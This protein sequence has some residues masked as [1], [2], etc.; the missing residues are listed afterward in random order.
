MAKA[1]SAKV[2][3]F[4]VLIVVSM[5]GWLT[6]HETDRTPYVDM[7]AVSSASASS[8]ASD[9][10]PP[11][12]M[13][14]EPLE[15]GGAGGAGGGEVDLDE[16]DPDAADRDP[17]EAPTLGDAPKAVKFG[18]ILVQYRGAQGASREARSKNEALALAQ[19][20]ARQGAEDF[21]AAVKRGDE[22]STANAGRMYRGILEAELEY[23]LFKLDEGALT[24]PVDT[25]RGYWVAKRLD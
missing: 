7:T 10:D 24:E 15:D 5:G 2:G 4:F 23:A 11:P 16:E 3:T 13:E 14:E 21:E 20:L 8:T 22:G 9:E 18:V 17:G 1:S 12:P 25:P 19:E 6:I